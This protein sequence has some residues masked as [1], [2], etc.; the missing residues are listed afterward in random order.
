MRT[1]ALGA[2]RLYQWSMSPYFRGYCRHTPTCSSYA[3]EAITR[4]GAIN[5]IWLGIR[6]LSRC[7]PLGTRGYDPVP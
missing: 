5:G 7:R 6:R 3:Y 4:Y 2:I 1:L